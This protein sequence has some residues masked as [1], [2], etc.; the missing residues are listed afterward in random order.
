M[1]KFIIRVVLHSANSENYERLHELMAAKRYSRQIED[2][3]GQIY[4]LPD[5]E[6]YAEKTLSAESVRED[7]RKLAD[8]V[9]PG[10]FV[11]VTKADDISWYLQPI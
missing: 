1:D 10:S 3:S 2:V 7:V 9:V 6:Y 8:S 11:L 4:Q 5:A